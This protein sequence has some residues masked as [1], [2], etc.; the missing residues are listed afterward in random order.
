M[1]SVLAQLVKRLGKDAPNVAAFYVG[2]QRHAYVVGK[3]PVDFLLRD[4]EGLATQWKTGRSTTETEARQ[5][6]STAATGNAFAPLFEEARRR[7][8]K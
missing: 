4:A 2:H 5:A 8:G 3:H 6:D 7:A 1:N